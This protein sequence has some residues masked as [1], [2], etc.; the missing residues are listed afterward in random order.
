MHAA[1][2]KYCLQ[3]DYL[4]AEAGSNPTVT[5]TMTSDLP[6]AENTKHILLNSNRS[7]TPMRFKIRSDA[8]I[9]QNVQVR[10][11]GTYI[12]TCDDAEGQKIEAAIELKVTSRNH[13]T[14]IFAGTFLAG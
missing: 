4:R 2:P 12:L 7:R 5:F 14:T 8:I 1:P 13:L 6:L 11:S 10:D 9:F 3:D